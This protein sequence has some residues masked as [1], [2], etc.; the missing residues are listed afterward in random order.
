M[1]SAI[2]SAIQGMGYFT[3]AKWHATVQVNLFYWAT[4]CLGQE[5]S[6]PFR[7]SR[8]CK[9]SAVEMLCTLE[10][11]HSIFIKLHNASDGIAVAAFFQL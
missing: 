5:G 8:S 2:A 1:C 11:M 9:S 10:I 3:E 6:I 4:S 7:F